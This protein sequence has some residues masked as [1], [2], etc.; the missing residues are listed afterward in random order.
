MIWHTF[1]LKNIRRVKRRLLRV[2]VLD[3]VYIFDPVTNE[4]FDV[5]TFDDSRRL[6]KMGVRTTPGE[7]HF[8]A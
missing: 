5:D 3:F 7:I 8:F 1:Y 2:R 6:L 4:I